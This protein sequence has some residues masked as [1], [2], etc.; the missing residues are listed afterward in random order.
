MKR[1]LI[2]MFILF[3]GLSG[4]VVGPAK[5]QIPVTDVAHIVLQQIRHIAELIDRALALYRQY[6][7]I[8]NQLQQIKFQLQALEKLDYSDPYNVGYAMGVLKDVAGEGS[9]LSYLRGVPR[10]AY[11]DVFPGWG[12]DWDE[13]EE[14]IT[15]ERRNFFREAEAAQ[16]ATLKTLAHIGKVNQQHVHEYERGMEV[17]RD[18]QERIASAKGHEEALEIIGHV[19]AFQSEYDFL[20]RM[21]DAAAQDAHRSFYSYLTNRDARVA[22]QWEEISEEIR[23]WSP[24]PAAREDYSVIPEWFRRKP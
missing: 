17:L 14:L 15:P 4:L 22:K 10:Y 1:V 6:Q 21:Q 11:E 2:A 8:T 9:P 24:V 12:E 23:D 20:G 18:L 16:E 5:A 13:N 19:L 3:F 7:Q